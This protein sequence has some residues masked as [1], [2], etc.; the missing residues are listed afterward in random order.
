MDNKLQELKD[1]ILTELE[2]VVNEYERIKKPR[3]IL[4]TNITEDNKILKSV[5]ITGESIV[6]KIDSMMGATNEQ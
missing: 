6:E 3:Y 4:T 2:P 5:L 1:W